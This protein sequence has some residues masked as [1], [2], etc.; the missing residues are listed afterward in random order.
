MD[1]I[2]FIKERNRMCKTNVSCYDCA[3]YRCADLHSCTGKCIAELRE[4]N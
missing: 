2:T 1:V 3:C 4:I